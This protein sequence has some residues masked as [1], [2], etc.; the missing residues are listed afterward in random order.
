MG[1]VISYIPTPKAFQYIQ[2]VPSVLA[3]PDLTAWFEGKLEDLVSGSLDYARY[4]VMLGR[5]VEHTL[6]DAKSGVALANMPSSEDVAHLITAKPKA[7]RAPRKS[8]PRAATKK[9]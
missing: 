6:V 3:K 1:K 7:A 2:C 8:K 5:L 9:P 4:R